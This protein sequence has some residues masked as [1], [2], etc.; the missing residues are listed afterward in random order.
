MEKWSRVKGIEG[1]DGK[2]QSMISSRDLHILQTSGKYPC[3]VYRNGIGKNSHLL[4]LEV[5]GNRS[6]GR[7]K[8]S[9]LDAIKD[10]LRQWNL[11]AKACQNRSEWRKRSKTASHTHAG[12]VT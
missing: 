9:W 12:R 3:A 6:R 1:A 7:Q 11:E 2:K 10:D 8:K 4:D 5:E